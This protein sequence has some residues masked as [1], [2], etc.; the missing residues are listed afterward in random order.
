[1]PLD[2]NLY[3]FKAIRKNYIFNIG[4]PICEK[5]KLLNLPFTYTGT[6]IDFFNNLPLGQVISYYLHV[7]L[8]EESST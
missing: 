7:Y 3:V 2:H 8:P 4:K 6:E 1:M 5:I